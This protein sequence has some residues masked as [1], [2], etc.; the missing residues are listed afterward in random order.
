MK[1]LVH[2]RLTSRSR[3]VAGL[4]LGTL[5]ATL[6]LAGCGSDPSVGA[7]S[8]VTGV[9]SAQSSLGSTVSLR[10]AAA[11]ERMAEL[12]ADGTFS[13]DVA[14]LTPPFT[15]KVHARDD[16]GKT[17]PIYSIAAQAGRT[18]INELSCAAV[19][20][21]TGESDDDDAEKHDRKVTQRAAS[22]F[23]ALITQ[24]R[25]VLAP[26]FDLYDVPADPL[27]DDGADKALRLMLHDVR[28]AVESGKLVVT[29]R[30]TGAVIFTGS[31][32][33]LAHG[34]F[35]MASM[36]AGPGMTPTPPGAA[37]NLDSNTIVKPAP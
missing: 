37:V 4:A 36:P 7:S 32:R 29:N 5:T 11:R 22:S 18:D 1:S 31:L 26:L 14:G 13:F 30:I 3:V 35:T 20:I 10:D 19:T 17:I 28:I 25:A 9:A 6:A 34:T 2:T 15:L 12:G 8:T 27:C 23:Q 33:D 24:L 21:A 16:A